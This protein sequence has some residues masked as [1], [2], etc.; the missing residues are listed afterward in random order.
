MLKVLCFKNQFKLVQRTFG[1]ITIKLSKMDGVKP[2]YFD[3]KKK[4]II[5]LT[6]LKLLISL[7]MMIVILSNIRKYALEL[8][9]DEA[10][11]GTIVTYESAK[12]TILDFNLNFAYLLYIIEK[13][14][15]E[16]LCSMFC[17]FWFSEIFCCTMKLNSIVFNRFESKFH[18]GDSNLIPI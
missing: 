1:K 2:Q 11:S 5:G 6:G 13:Y 10:A 18:C 4:V 14:D 9:I 8:M 12:V 15:R 17:H 3:L 16:F 7:I